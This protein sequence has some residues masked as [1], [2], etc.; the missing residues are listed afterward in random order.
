M[1]EHL[2]R[3]I[4]RKDEHER[5]RKKERKRKKK[6]ERKKKKGE[7]KKMKDDEF[8]DDGA[9]KMMRMKIIIVDSLFGTR[10]V[11]LVSVCMS[12]LCDTG[13]KQ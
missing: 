11:K 7:K 4:C 9:L 12:I 6:R 13:I 8:S 10:C 2:E 3:K 1:I 5:E